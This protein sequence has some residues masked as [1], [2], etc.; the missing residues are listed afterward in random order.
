MHAS[1]QTDSKPRHRWAK[2]TLIT[3]A[4]TAIVAVA[5]LGYATFINAKINEESTSHLTEVYTQVNDKFASLVSE[6]WS[7]LSSWAY[8]IASVPTGDDGKVDEFVGQEQAK[9]GFTDFF[10]LNRD[11]GYLTADGEAGYIDLGDQLS[12]L[13]LEGNNIVVDGTLPTGAALTVFA[14]PTVAEGS[15]QGFAYS[16]IAVSYNNAD[17]EAALDVEAFGGQS[18]CYVTYANG[19]VLLS[20]NI[21]EGQ[22]HNYLTYI[23][24]NASLT[25]D[26]FALLK[27]DIS[28]GLAGAAQY[29]L[30]GI[31][32]YLV[33]QPVGFEDWMMLGIV[34][35]D[36]VNAAMNEIQWV[37]VGVFSGIFI[38]IGI[39]AVA[40]LLRR[41]KLAIKGK[42]V[43]IEYREHLLTTLVENTEDIFVM[44]SADD[45]AV[46]Y[47]SPNIERILGIPAQ[48]VRDDLRTLDESAVSMDGTPGRSELNQIAH[49]KCWQGDRERIHQRTGERRWY[50]ETIYRESIGDTEKFILVL[51]DRTKEREN[52]EMLKQALDIAWHSNEAKSAFLANMSHDIRTP[53][54][55][56]L[57]MI[58]LAQLNLSSA[59]KVSE[60]LGKAKSSANHLLGLI[61]DILDMSKIESGQMTLQEKPCILDQMLDETISIIE[62]QAKAKRQELAVE[63]S[64]VEHRAFIGDPVRITQ[65]LLN[66]LSNAVK[67]TPEGGSIRF[68]VEEL[69]QTNPT[70]ARLRFNVADTGIGMPPEFLEH[71]FDPFERSNQQ[72]VESI[73]GTGLGMPIA[74][75]LVEAMGGAI[76]VTSEVGVGS[77]F[78]VVLDLRV[79][80]DVACADETEGATV[81]VERYVFE[82]KRFLMA[83]DNEI[84]A[85]VLI[86]LLGMRGAIVEWAENGEQAVRMFAA[87]PSGYYDAVFMDVQMPVMGGYD[88][89]AAIRAL[90]REDAESATIIALTANAFAEDVQAALSAG[91]NAHVAKPIIMEE[92]EKTL[93]GLGC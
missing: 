75:S 86:E 11:G 49:D 85:M 63:A 79:D 6:N 23:E 17:M 74:K 32:Y 60:N 71:I 55:G 93:L 41:S 16:A 38:L 7:H 46:E 40:A 81:Q 31:D 9:W 8:H 54:N 26:E 90:P 22:P 69:E 14:V 34:P 42:D 91:M 77:T 48:R 59:E 57:G 18:D 30:D 72:A 47:V 15:Y 88:A 13:M 37:T 62:P 61:N 83:E 1:W 68:V 5:C 20:T 43:E 58:D 87:K 78:E 45:Y 73:Q 4:V 76:S 24:G 39:V 56:I 67:Y 36:V 2:T 92:L 51:A 52:A 53:I 70:F 29:R 50:V 12:S 28:S 82:G 84:N 21:E 35:R 27:E 25:E 44:F 80:Q 66:L 33:Y 65:V 10:F 64:Q 3:T 89:T 19:R